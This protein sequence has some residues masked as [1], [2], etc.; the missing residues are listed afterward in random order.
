MKSSSKIVYIVI[1]CFAL[2]VATGCATKQVKQSG[3]LENYPEFKPGPKGGADFVY[4]KESVDFKRYNKIMMDHVV[5]YFRDDA[6]YKGIHPEE[7]NEMSN[8][9][10]KAIADNLEGAYPLVVEPGSDVMRLRF[11]ITDVVASNPGMGTISTVMPIG[12][13]LSTIKKGVT[14]THTGVGQASIEV[15]ILDSMTNER[16]A[17]AIDTKPG[18]KIEGFS[19]WGAVEGAFEFWAKRLRHWLDETHGREGD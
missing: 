13:A 5:L 12:L 3:F 18:G 17:V 4:M 16:I 7:L 2:T 19:K 1:I 10:H 15:E 14:G 9:F 6:K 8:A 11:A